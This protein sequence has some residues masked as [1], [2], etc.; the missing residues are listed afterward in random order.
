MSISAPPTIWA[1]RM[2]WPR[3]APPASPDVLAAAAEPGETS[4]KSAPFGP[5]IAAVVAPVGER[6][7]RG[8][9][10]QEQQIVRRDTH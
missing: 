5:G 1:A 8:G 2:F 4:E 7:L 3:C 10:E 6:R 9:D